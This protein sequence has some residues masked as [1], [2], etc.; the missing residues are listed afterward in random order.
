MAIDSA[1]K[2]RGISGLHLYAAGPGE[3]PTGTV[4]RQTSGY[5]YIGIPATEYVPGAEDIE[6]WFDYPYGFDCTIE[7]GPA[8]LPNVG[9]TTERRILTGLKP[10]RSRSGM[11]PIRT[12]LG[13]DLSTS[14]KNS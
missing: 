14:E 12:R 10:V 13:L 2:R 6:C 1:P 5:G 8:P 11:K 9:G 7:I 4:D 3:T